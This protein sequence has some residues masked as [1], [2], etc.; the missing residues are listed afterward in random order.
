MIVEYSFLCKLT[1]GLS[2]QACNNTNLNKECTNL[3]DPW[4]PAERGKLSVLLPLLPHLGAVAYGGLSAV[5][6]NGLAEEL[7][8]LEQLVGLLALVEPFQKRQRVLV[9][10]VL[11][12]ELCPAAHG[13]ADVVKLAAA[14][15][16]F[17]HVDHLESD[18]A[19]LEPPLCLFGVKALVRAENLDVHG[20][21]PHKKHSFH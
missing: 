9:L 17:L 2:K 21:S 12:D 10:C 7:L 3:S 16:L 6:H 14:H 13:A 8:V 5:A 19:L 15:A 18:A 1:K 4:A 20:H 11:V